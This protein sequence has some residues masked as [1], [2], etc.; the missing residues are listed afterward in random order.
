MIIEIEML[1]NSEL[2]RC[3]Y[4]VLKIWFAH[5]EYKLLKPIIR[6]YMDELDR[7]KLRY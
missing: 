7:R 3:Y 2:A 4:L 5:P 1:G 6:A